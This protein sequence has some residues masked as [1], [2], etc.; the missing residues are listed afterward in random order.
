MSVTSAPATAPST[1]APEPVRPSSS[2]PVRRP[3]VPR[4]VSL[5][6]LLTGLIDLVSALTRAERARLH[7]LATLVP[8]ELTTAS[9][10][11]TLVTG[12]LLVL[13]ARGLRRRKRRAWQVAVGLLLSSIALHALKGLDVEE[14]AV[15]CLLL[16]GMVVLRNEFYAE[17]DPRTR[18]R[19]VG[20]GVSLFVTSF[21]LG[22][23]FIDIRHDALV[24]PF[25]SHHRLTGGPGGAGRGRR[26]ARVPAEPVR[27]EN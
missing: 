13:L 7:E 16:V 19:A 3:W 1:S 20:I 25:Q 23:A 11:L 18:W 4:V 12:I 8:G 10:A 24:R 26:A 15:A 14:A 6:C 5:L 27:S 21:V 9:N 22:L 2:G 17:G